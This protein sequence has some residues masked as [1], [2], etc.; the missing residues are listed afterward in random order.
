MNLDGYRYMLVIAEILLLAGLAV[1]LCVAALGDIRSYRI[2]NSLN[3]AIAALALPYW[4][5]HVANQNLAIWPLARPQ[6]IVIGISFIV[7][8]PMMLLNLIGGGDAKLLFALAFW[9][10]PRLYLDMIT[11][12]SIAGG[13]LCFAILVRR[14]TQHAVPNIGIDGEVVKSSFKQR[15][16]YG[17]AI[18]VGGLVPTSQ[19]ILNAFMR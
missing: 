13:V 11:M 12:T 6:L 3:I 18:S 16:P 5:A 19:L 15:V 4:Y 1:L 8:L 17:V 9:L 7:L 10:Q 2:S 14:R